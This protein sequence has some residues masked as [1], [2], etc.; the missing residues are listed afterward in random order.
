[1]YYAL[2]SDKIPIY[3]DDGNPT[4]ETEQGYLPPV[5]FKA[6]LSAGNSMLD[7]QPFGSNVSY[8]RVILLYDES[9]IDEHALIWVNKEPVIMVGG[10]PDPDSADYEVSGAPLIFQPDNRKWRTERIPIRRRV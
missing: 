1:M 5:Q 8:D 10:Y 3:D 7:E 4:L 9:P 2:F 6:N